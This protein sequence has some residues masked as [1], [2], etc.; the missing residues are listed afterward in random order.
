MTLGP[1]KEIRIMNFDEQINRK[2][3]NCAK[4]DRQGGDY[5]PLW[6]AD[7]DF[8]VAEPIMEALRK[9]LEHPVFGYTGPGES[10]YQA[11]ID[12]YASHY[13]CEV[14]KEWIVF[15][16]GVNQGN[17][18]A[19]EALGGSILVTTPMYPHINQKLPLEAGKPILRVPLKKQGESF[20]FDFDALEQAVTD[21]VTTFVLC[22]P[23]N[24][25]GRVYTRQELKEL[26][27]FAKRYNITV[28]ADEIHSDLIFEGEHIPAFTLGDEEAQRVV[29][30]HSASK[31]YNIP[32]LPLAFAII[33]NRELR[34]WY[35]KAALKKT[36]PF[37]VLELTALEAALTKGESW[38]QE[39]IAY[40]RGNRDYLKER[41]DG[42]PGL[43]MYPCNATYLAWV[44]AGGAGIENP[45]EFFLKNAGV[46]FND[47]E[48]FSAKGFFRVN[49]G[50]PRANLAEAFDRV[51][52][53][54]R[55]HPTS[56]DLAEW[57]R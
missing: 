45:R 55:F 56:A 34:K 43:H 54:L 15:I 46:H 30:H 14:K 44:N 2:N 57:K 50:C 37:G 42:I 6:V 17:C 39:L 27:A 10:L 11:V 32:G 7:M 33:P 48:P 8:A 4:W 36:S 22:N 18:I 51:E 3:T 5:I 21:K 20:T 13:H 24:P 19:A 16:H 41:I 38:R 47:G 29:V 25:V 28:V 40:L 23:H 52:R 49:F 31:T 1:V 9:R 53:A 35:E 12:Y 26:F